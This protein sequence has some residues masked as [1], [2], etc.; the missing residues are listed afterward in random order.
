[1]EADVKNNSE[2]GYKAE[3]A[4]G[5]VCKIPIKVRIYDIQKNSDN[6]TPAPRR[7]RGVYCFTSVG[8]SVHQ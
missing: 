7:G 3:I 8:P 5:V 6:Y 2:T 1:L 4:G